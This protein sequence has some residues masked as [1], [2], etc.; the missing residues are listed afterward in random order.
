ML[1]RRERCALLSE[2]V[3]VQ[4]QVIDQSQITIIY[5]FWKWRVAAKALSSTS[6]S[7]RQDKVTQSRKKPKGAW[8]EALSRKWILPILRRGDLYS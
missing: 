7:M 8:G 2:I 1:F 5:R 4:P 6:R 3:E